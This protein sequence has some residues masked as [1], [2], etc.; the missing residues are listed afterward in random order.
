MTHFLRVPV[1]PVTRWQADKAAQ[2]EDGG[3]C[4]QFN[5][6]AAEFA[7]EQSGDALQ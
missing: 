5:E 3:G 7:A 2:F 4:A 6:F 1:G